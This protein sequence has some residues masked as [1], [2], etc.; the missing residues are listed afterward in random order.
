MV[1]SSCDKR[2]P[3]ESRFCMYCSQSVGITKAFDDIVVV[4][5]ATIESRL[6]EGFNRIQAISP[7][8]TGIDN[9]SMELLILPPG[10]ESLPH[11]HKNVHTVVYII[12]GSV[13]AYVGE[14][15]EKYHDILSGDFV[16]VPPDVIHF[17]I[18]KG[19]EVLVAVV[20]RTPANSSVVE[21]KE[22]THNVRGVDIIH[23]VH[24]VIE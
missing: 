1:C 3:E 23:E 9:I 21:F 14:R 6:M 12:G 16:Y 18:N 20:A 8:T 4:K 24:E 15:L 19:N 17:P 22:L 13:R 11:A 7:E 5:K 2:I 10:A